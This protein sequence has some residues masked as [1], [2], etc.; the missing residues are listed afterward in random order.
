M[1]YTFSPMTREDARE[2]ATWQYEAPY[3]VYN[4]SADG[5]DMAELLDARSPYFAARDERGMLVGWFAYGTTAEVGLDAPPGLWSEDHMIS[6]GLGMR[7]DLTG[8]GLGLEYV[9]AGLDF[10]REQFHPARFRLFVLAFNERAAK[11]YERAG[12]RR[13]RVV[14][15]RNRYGKR[16]FIEMRR[17]A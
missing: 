11:V 14:T 6:M 2:I 7:P 9:A 12:F 17:E 8:R 4:I 15:V 10:A 16:D 13:L 5:E 1:A 3:G